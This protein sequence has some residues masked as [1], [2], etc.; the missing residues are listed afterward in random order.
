MPEVVFV[1]ALLSSVRTSNRA[2]ERLERVGALTLAVVLVVRRGATVLLRAVFCRIGWY[3]SP[4]ELRGEGP[5]CRS[6]F[7]ARSTAGDVA[8]TDVDL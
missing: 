5:R 1:G 6:L 8:S 2:I 7:R 3:I 4:I